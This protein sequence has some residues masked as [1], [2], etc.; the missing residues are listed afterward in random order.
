MKEIRE[1]KIVCS[2]C[3][4]VR[5]TPY[6]EFNQNTPN[7]K[8]KGCLGDGLF[9]AAT[10]TACLPLGCCSTLASVDGVVARNRTPDEQR[11]LYFVLQKVTT[12][13]KC[14]S[15]AKTIET[16]THVVP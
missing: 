9:T 2:A 10:Y 14:G 12:C 11:E 3:G 15:M 4:E 7:D 6:A 16:V 5:H 1:F 8:A 13:K